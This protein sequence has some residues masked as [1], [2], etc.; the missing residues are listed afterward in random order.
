MQPAAPPPTSFI[1]AAT[2]ILF[3]PGGDGA[4]EILMLERARGMAFA[5]GMLVFPG[6]RIDAGDRAMAGDHDDHAARIAAIRET[7]EE[8]GLAPGLTP[9]PDAACIAALRAGL[10]AGV[11]FAA[12]LADAG[13]TLDR[14][15]LVPFARWRPNMH[16]SRNFDTRF[17][18]AA[19]PDGVTETVDGS[20]CV[21]ARWAT[22]ATFLA[23]DRVIF[24]TRRNLERLAQHRDLPSAIADA[25]RF[26]P[27]P[28]TPWIETRDGRDWL[29]IPADIGYPVT[30]EPVSEALRG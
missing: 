19:A 5:A 11:P 18:L 17:Y 29:T 28:I 14:E 21:S 6:G 15:A 10:A 3:R 16:H 2:V 7:I 27:T 9:S 24:P 8:A 22:A 1:P 12:L 13:L 20:E 30:A 4:A 23:S 26:P 25:R